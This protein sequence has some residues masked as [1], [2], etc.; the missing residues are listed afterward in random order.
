MPSGFT[1]VVPLLTVAGL[2][3]LPYDLAVNDGGGLDFAWRPSQTREDV[4]ADPVV[5]V[6]VR[7]G[8]SPDGV[9]WIVGTCVEVTG[10]DAHRARWWPRRLGGASRP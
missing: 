4:L 6:T 1:P 8:G 7:R 9:G 10:D 2:A 3:A 5:R